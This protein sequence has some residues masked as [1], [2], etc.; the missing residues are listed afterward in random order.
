MDKYRLFYVY[1]LADKRIDFKDY[2]LSE[3]VGEIFY[4]ID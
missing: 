2:L 3:N 4:L 1:L